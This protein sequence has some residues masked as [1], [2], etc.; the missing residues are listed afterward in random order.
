VKK[1]RLQPEGWAPPRGYA[2]GIAVSGASQLIF[3]GG[4][5]GWNDQGEFESDDFIDQT[6]QALKNIANEIVVV[7]TGLPDQETARAIW[8]RTSFPE[9]GQP[10]IETLRKSL[11]DK[12]GAPQ[13]DERDRQ[14]RITLTWVHDL[15]G[16]PMSTV[17]PALNTCSRGLGAAFASSHSWSAGCGLTIRAQISP[18]WGNDLLAREMSLGLM[19]Q[20]DFYDSGQ[21]FERDLLAAH[22]ASKREQADAAAASGSGVDL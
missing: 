5:I 15:L 17:A 6:R 14:G 16:R 13:L 8:R 19:H 12:Y 4:Q 11:T 18:V 7:F 9:G 1:K 20:K 10:A 21:Q 2:N 3:L 22:E